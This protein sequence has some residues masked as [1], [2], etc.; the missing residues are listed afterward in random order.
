MQASR[1]DVLRTTAHKVRG[2][3]ACVNVFDVLA[4]S[5]APRPVAPRPGLAV[6][7]ETALDGLLRDAPGERSGRLVTLVGRS[8]LLSRAQLRSRRRRHRARFARGDVAYVAT[9]DGELAAWAWVALGPHVDCRWSGLHF[10]LDPGDAYLYDLWSFPV[11]RSSGAGAFVVEEMLRDLRERGL[12]DRAFGYVLRG[13][14]ASQ[15]MHRLVL[16]FSQVQEVRGVRV[17]S[18]WAWQ[19]PDSAVP[20]EGPCGPVPARL[21]QVPA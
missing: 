13:N 10:E 15:V 17:M 21:P 9:L 19:V 3:V 11:V 14:R 2:R 1:T 8:A 16:G 18:H 7:R 6:V 4:R 12:A 20:P 5:T